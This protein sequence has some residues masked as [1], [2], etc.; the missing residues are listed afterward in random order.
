MFSVNINIQIVLCN[1]GMLQ[2]RESRELC[3]GFL[4]TASD[5]YL[6][7]KC[8]FKTYLSFN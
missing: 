7:S 5:N 1:Y 6:N 8:N 3:N 2:L 4:D